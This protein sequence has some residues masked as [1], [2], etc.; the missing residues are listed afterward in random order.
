[1]ENSGKCCNV[2]LHPYLVIMRLDL[3]SCCLLLAGHWT[4]TGSLHPFVPW[5][6]GLH[7]Q[8]LKVSV[9]PLSA[10][11]ICSRHMVSIVRSN[12]AVDLETT[13]MP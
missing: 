6:H 7:C 8:C 10:L 2:L 3:Y 5:R 11:S 1:M 12:Q 4:K 13:N 9:E